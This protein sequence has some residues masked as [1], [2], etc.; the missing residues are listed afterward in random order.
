MYLVYPDVLTDERANDT[1]ADFLRQKIRERVTDPA[2]A[3]L[4]IPQGYPVLTKRLCADTGY[5][6]T[7][8]RENVS[9][10]D[11]RGRSIAISPVGIIADGREHAV[12]S[13]ILA[14]GFDAL[15]G[16]LGRM[17]IRGTGDQLLSDHWKHGA[18][19]AYGLMVAGFP[20]MFLLDGPGSP[21]PVFHPILLT[22]EQADWVG[23]WI[24]HLRDNQLS[25]IEPT[26]EVEEEWVQ[27][28][29]DAINATLFPRAASWY[30][31]ANIQGKTGI[32]LVDFGG[33]VH[34]R[35]SCAGVLQSGFRGFKLA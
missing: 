29:T 18:R 24:S 34:Y 15:T 22:E 5:Y 26:A 27:H 10:V 6:E 31:G 1:L 11:V 19:T 8:N 3:D 33:I 23:D 16:A 30:V 4:L 12:N 2:V 14:T 13:I 32:G 17:E 35:Q 28:C 7:Y 9:L 20:N 25:C 21:C